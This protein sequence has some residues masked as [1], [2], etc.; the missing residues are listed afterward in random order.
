MSLPSVWTRQ[1][2]W[3]T[4][5]LWG[6]SIRN[7]YDS[8]SADVW[9]GW[10]H[11]DEDQWWNV[12]TQWVDGAAGARPTWRN[13]SSQ[14]AYDSNAYSFISDP[15][16]PNW[17]RNLSDPYTPYGAMSSEIIQSLLDEYTR[18][19]KTYNLEG[20][21]GT[22]G[23]NST[24]TGVGGWEEVDKWNNEI[25][26]AQQQVYEDTGIFVP[27]NLIKAIM[28]TESGGI[29][30]DSDPGAGAIGVMQVMPFWADSLGLNLYDHYENIL[31]GVRILASNY[32]TG[33]LAGNPSWEW[34]TRRY[35]GLGPGGDAYGTT[36]ETYWNKVQSDWNTLNS[37]VMYGMGEDGSVASPLGTSGL[38]DLARQFVGV[39]YVWGGIPG[40]GVDPWQYGG[41]DC[42]GFLYWLDQNHGGRTLTM[43]SHYQ[44]QDARNNNRLF[45]NASGLQA[46]DIV[47][48]D[49]GLRNGGGAELNNASHV[50]LYLGNGQFIHAANPEVGTIVSDFSSYADKFI[51]AEHHAWNVSTGMSDRFASI[52][53]GVPF[54]ITQEYGRT[55]WSQGE[56]RWLYTYSADLG[57]EGG[58]AH[59]GVDVGTPE[60]T[61]LY[62]PVGG[63]VEYVGA[64][65]GF[66]YNFQTDLPN[67]GG[68]YIRLDNGDLL[69][70]GHMRS[71]S[72][73]A[74]DRV[75]A[76]NFVGLS[77]AA[78]G[79]HVHVE[80]RKPNPAGGE[81]SVD[82]RLALNGLF[83]GTYDN[84]GMWTQTA[85]VA[86]SDNW[87][88]FMRAVAT[89]KEFSGYSGASGG[90]YRDF[91][92]RGVTQGWDFAATQGA[93]GSNTIAYSW[94]ISF[95]Q[96]GD[97]T[98]YA[99]D[100]S[101][102]A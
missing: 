73:K 16:D 19:T 62:S 10:A 101:S 37:A 36:H 96:K 58:G 14:Q 25:I 59:P 94:G 55:E 87:L 3:A 90:A 85:P 40:Y 6:Q 26:N 88:Q 34:A 32:Q 8:R 97:W 51:G 38:L 65:R 17:G 4:G 83:A 75:E 74:G 47:Y 12:F 18:G 60:G 44:Y 39:P 43:G 84:A 82:P 13:Y 71:I 86:T 50:G 89:G 76:G 15:F 9:G 57:W 5:D 27:G 99:D 70:L 35:L 102:G 41:W 11:E 31:A 21:A 53:H 2:P 91:L 24:A 23:A 67:S 49:T 28:K 93:V 48:F 64:D 56:G 30:T 68:L 80:Y 33:D 54:P 72:V 95:G 98:Q 61:H 92:K 45:Y 1:S 52:T 100:V 77:G 69:I 42:S 81:L 46:G 79:A 66:S 29:W 22:V 63:T 7:P 20:T 78:N